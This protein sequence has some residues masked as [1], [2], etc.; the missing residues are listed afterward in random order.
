MNKPANG[1]K[2]QLYN[3]ELK[4]QILMKLQNIQMF[5]NQSL[6]ILLLAAVLLWPKM[7]NKLF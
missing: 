3:L 1:N 6:L 2:I 4:L 5:W 7:N